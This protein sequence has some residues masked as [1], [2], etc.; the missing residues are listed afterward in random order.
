[1]CQT[2]GL[3]RLLQTYN[4]SPAYPPANV[5]L[6]LRLEQG[7]SLCISLTGIACHLKARLIV[8]F[9]DLSLFTIESLLA[10]SD[11]MPCQG[12][13]RYIRVKAP[14]AIDSLRVICKGL[15]ESVNASGPECRVPR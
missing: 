5:S 6:F 2:P 11:S 14:E 9:C 4:R 13:Q 12:Q 10:S 7:L 15:E 1:M 3:S 8:L